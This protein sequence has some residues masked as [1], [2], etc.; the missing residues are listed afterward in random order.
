MLPGFEQA[1]APP[2]AAIALLIKV[3]QLVASHNYCAAHMQLILGRVSALGVYGLRRQS[4]PTTFAWQC[5]MA[6]SAAS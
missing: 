2:H 1:D 5:R 4:G 6:G 3:F